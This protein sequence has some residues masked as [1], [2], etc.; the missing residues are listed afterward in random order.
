MHVVSTRSSSSGVWAMIRKSV[1]SP[2]GEMR[3]QTEWHRVVLFGKLAEVAGEYLR[4]GAQV[5]IEGQLR[6]R[7]WE[8][9]GITR[10]VTEILVKTTGTMQMLGSAPQQNAQ[11]QPQPQQNGQSQSADATKKV[12]RKRKAVD[13]RLRSRSLS[14]NHRRGRITGFQTISRSDWPDCDNRPVLRGASPEI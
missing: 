4:K 10:Y 7:S 5:Y 11:V 9:N 3:E 6:T 12:A 14:R 8:D 13:V 2:T 1:T